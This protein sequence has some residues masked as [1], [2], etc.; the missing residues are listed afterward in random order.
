MV[1]ISAS[2]FFS[3]LL[4]WYVS[5]SYDIFAS[6]RDSAVY[7]YPWDWDWG[8]RN[9]T[10]TATSLQ[11]DLICPQ[12][13]KVYQTTAHASKCQWLW[14]LYGADRTSC[15]YRQVPFSLPCSLVQA[16]LNVRRSFW[17]QLASH[18][19]SRLFY[20]LLNEIIWS[21]HPVS[22]LCSLSCKHLLCCCSAMLL[23]RAII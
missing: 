10:S 17:N 14:C 13:R 22:V 9:K 15:N 20:L 19:I 8:T 23:C 1:R 5:L 21:P 12:K 3:G 2:L 6:R 16:G 18:Q 4:A 11:S 7:V